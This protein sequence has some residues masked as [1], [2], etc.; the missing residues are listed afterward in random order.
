MGIITAI[1][2]AYQVKWFF[3]GL[4][5]M[6]ILW[7]YLGLWSILLLI[8][9]LTY[10]VYSNIDFYKRKGEFDNIISRKTI[11]YI[12]GIFLGFFLKEDIIQFSIK[13]VNY[14]N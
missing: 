1:L 9:P 8:L 11:A 12:L 2:V 3:A 6:P 4:I 7:Y 5:L 14:F 13:L 10:F